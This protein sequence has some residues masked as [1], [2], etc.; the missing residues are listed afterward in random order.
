MTA[1]ISPESSASIARIL[2]VSECPEPICETLAQLGDSVQ[3]VIAL[4][5]AAAL[6]DLQAQIFDVCILDAANAPAVLPELTRQIQFA[7]LDT[8]IV[9]L[10]SEEPSHV[11]AK[12]P[13]ETVPA[14]SPAETLCCV[15]RSAVE[16]A[17]LHS[18]NRLLKR[19]LQSR[20]LNELVGQSESTNQLREAICSAADDEGC[21]LIHGEAG[22]G[23]QYAG[24]LLHL[25][26]RRATRPFLVLD[27]AIHCADSVERELF[28]EHSRLTGPDNE[29]VCGRLVA[30]AGGSLLLKNVEALPLSVQRKLVGI[31][32]RN[33]FHCPVAGTV[34]PLEARILASTHVDLAI[35]A[36]EGR[37]H[38]E[39]YQLLTERTIAVPS[40]RERAQ[41]LGR[42]CEEVLNRMS[43]SEG[44]PVKRLSVEALKLI[45]THEWRNNFRELEAVMERVSALDDG[46]LLTA[47]MLR[48]WITQPLAESAEEPAGLSLREMERK[49]IETTFAR[50][51][52]NRE[53]TARLLRIGIRTLSGKLREYGYPPRGGPGSNRRLAKAA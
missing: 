26:G 16:K 22:A 24:R 25:A 7:N 29:V 37:F 53:Q 20:I 17:L 47:E 32:T 51:A 30:C 15:V 14:A 45:R 19:Q 3:I 40:L 5:V 33:A 49:L 34:R 9:H 38:I 28:G 46:G 23:C 39:L 8:C 31:L 52:G 35:E 36:Q 41:D 27:C 50:C 43:A 18:E 13:I 1:T 4:D 10:T 12:I 48:P 6:E 21:V 42:L 11:A 44:K 2:L